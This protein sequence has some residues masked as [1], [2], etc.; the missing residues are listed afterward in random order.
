MCHCV[1]CSYHY[2]D[3]QYTV[4]NYLGFWY[5]EWCHYTTY[6]MLSSIEYC[7]SVCH[8]DDCHYLV[9][10]LSLSWVLSTKCHYS[11]CHHDEY[12]YLMCWYADI[13]YAD[14]SNSECLYAL[15]FVLLAW[16]KC[17]TVQQWLTNLCLH[18]I[19]QSCVY[20]VSFNASLQSRRKKFSTLLGWPSKN[21]LRKSYEHFCA[22]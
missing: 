8:Y 4:C 5:S 3:C 22:G 11:A 10:W 2:S 6:W 12:H 19:N 17:I 13:W 16:T 7:Y 1:G 20:S 21:L 15:Y 14:Y 9:C 18:Q